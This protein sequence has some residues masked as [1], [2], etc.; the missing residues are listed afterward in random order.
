[1]DVPQVLGADKLVHLTLYFVLALF[2]NH[3]VRRPRLVYALSVTA[4]CGT[5][6]GVMEL[7]QLYV[8]GRGPDLWDAL[9]NLTGAAVAGAVYVRW[10][11]RKAGEGRSVSRH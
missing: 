10:K 8:P 4:G 6:G 2:V 1:V 9:A 7:L 5:L 3:A 11:S